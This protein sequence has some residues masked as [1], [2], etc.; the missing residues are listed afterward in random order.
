[1]GWYRESVASFV[2]IRTKGA[3]LLA[4][5]IGYSAL[6]F[7]RC[8]ECALLPWNLARLGYD[9]RSARDVLLWLVCSDRAR[10]DRFSDPRAY[11]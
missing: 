5:F 2:P 1:M 4:S 7:Y 6:R 8:D 3:F 11:S 9:E 10:R